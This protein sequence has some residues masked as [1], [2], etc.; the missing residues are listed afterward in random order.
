MKSVVTS[1]QPVKGSKLDDIVG[2]LEFCLARDLPAEIVGRWVWLRFDQKPDQDTR[3]A[4]KAAG[5]RWCKRRAAWAHNCGFP[6]R[7]GV[8]DPRMKYGAIPVNRQ[9]VDDLA[10]AV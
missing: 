4:L 7:A 6:C 9:I 5:F 3:S 8:G 2:V 1:G 10:T